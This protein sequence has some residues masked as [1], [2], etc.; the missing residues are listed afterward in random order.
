MA[1]TGILEALRKGPVSDSPL[2]VFTDG[3]PKDVSLLQAAKIKAQ[4]LGVTVYFFLTNGCGNETDYLPFEEL[5]GQ[6]CGQIFELPKSRSDI[7]KMKRY[8]KTLLEGTA[9]IGA[10]QIL[11][12][13]KKKRSVAAKEYKLMV[14]DTMDKIIVSISTANSS[15]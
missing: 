2:Y 13:G 12:I 9:C 14:D 1:F 10:F 15:P 6:T 5:A 7:A 11:L 3:P 4:L 8:T